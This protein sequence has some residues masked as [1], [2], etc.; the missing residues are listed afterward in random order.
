MSSANDDQT[1]TTTATVVDPPLREEIRRQN[2]QTI[3]GYVIL[4]ATSIAAFT[5]LGVAIH[6]L[7]VRAD[8]QAQQT[9]AMQWD[10]YEGRIA[11]RAE[12]FAVRDRF[13]L[14]PGSDEYADF[15]DITDTNLPALNP[16]ACTMP[17]DLNV[18]LSHP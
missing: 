10:R 6:T 14:D 11:T 3:I 18:I 1:T 17:N 12:L 16:P 7:R 8:D 13:V 9:C 15:T 4:A 5:G 2:R